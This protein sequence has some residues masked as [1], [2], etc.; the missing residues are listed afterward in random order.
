MEKLFKSCSFNLFSKEI[1]FL[2]GCRAGSA[3]ARVYNFT[4]LQC[5]F[6]R[7]VTSKLKHNFLPTSYYVK[8]R[9]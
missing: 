2:R 6:V 8:V 9:Y 4:D 1:L 7:N 3:L 5:E